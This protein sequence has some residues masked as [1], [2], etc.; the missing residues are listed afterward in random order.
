MLFEHSSFRHKSVTTIASASFS[1]QEINRRDFGIV[2]FCF[3]FCFFV[4]SAVSACTYFTPTKDANTFF[5]VQ[6][7]RPVHDVRNLS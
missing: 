6:S 3:C 4:F 7:K 5:I 2:M 1:E